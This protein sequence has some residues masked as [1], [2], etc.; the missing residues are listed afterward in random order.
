[1]PSLRSGALRCVGLVVLTLFAAATSA[2]TARADT[3]LR[4]KFKEGAK[5]HFEM[6]MEMVQDTKAGPM[7]FQVKMNQIMDMTWEVKS[8]GDDGTA[9][10]NQTIDRVRMEMVL[11][12]AGQPPIKYDSQ[13]K[14]KAPGT[15]MLARI[16]EIMIGKPFVLRVTP[17]GKVLDLSAPADL[18]AA[19]KG[20]SPQQMGGLFSEDGLKQMISQSMMPLP[21]EDVAEGATWE[22]SAEMNTPP[23]GKQVTTTEYKFVGPE[24][25]DG[26]NLD[27]IDVA[28]DMKFEAG[29]DTQ[30]KLK[31]KDNKASGEI[32]W[33]NDT[34][35][36]AESTVN[37]KMTFEITV[38]AQTIEQTVSTK[39][40]MK[41][42]ADAATRDL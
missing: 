7:P 12:Q 39:V 25:R 4:W 2:M 3:T 5:N 26:R 35:L 27:K 1:M 29:G 17:L 40:R 31:L 38:E 22:K 41:H 23:F 30:A 14:E 34:G 8:V 20:A 6:T 15:E 19:L 10:M 9:T 42:V 28:L 36:P 32:Y 33:D 21:E 37:S 18:V 24:A 13:Q 11:P 16:F